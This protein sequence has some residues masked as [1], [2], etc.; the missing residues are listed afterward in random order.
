MNSMYGSPIQHIPRTT[1][2][3]AATYPSRRGMQEDEKKY[4][5]YQNK[6]D[7]IPGLKKEY[8]HE[9][10]INNYVLVDYTQKPIHQN[11]TIAENQYYSKNKTDDEMPQSGDNFS[12][13]NY[14]YTVWQKQEIT[15]GEKPV[16]IAIARLHSI[17]PTFE[18]W[19]SY[20]IDILEPLSSDPSSFGAGK[21]WQVPQKT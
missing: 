9:I 6:K 14:H 18:Q 10:Q 11:T 12:P 15:P 4:W 3:F 13:S 2:K 21:E 7:K 19:G 20:E 8:I 16:Y 17:L 5:E 1:F